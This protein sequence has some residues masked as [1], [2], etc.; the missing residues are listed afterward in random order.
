MNPGAHSEL[1]PIF[2]SY[3]FLILPAGFGKPV[4]GIGSYS[5]R[6]Q[7]NLSSASSISWSVLTGLKLMLTGIFMQLLHSRQVLSACSVSHMGEALHMDMKVWS[8]L[9]VTQWIRV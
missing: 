6:K 8:S 9:M 7:D 5:E 2:F 4:F 3:S 1:D